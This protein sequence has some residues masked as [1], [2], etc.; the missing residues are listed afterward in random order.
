MKTN[1]RL[2]TIPDFMIALKAIN[3]NAELSVTD[4]HH[5]TRITYAHLHVLKQLFVQKGWVNIF[6]EGVKHLLTVTEK[7]KSIVE[8]IN[9]LL[10]RL[11]IDK[12]TLI[13]FRARTKHNWKE[14][15]EEETPVVKENVEEETPAVKEKVEEEKYIKT[16]PGVKLTEPVV[17]KPLTPLERIEA[18]QLI[19]EPVVEE[20]VV[21]EPVVEEPVAE[22]V[23]E[24]P[25]VEEPV[26]EEPVVEEP[27]VED[28]DEIVDDDYV[29]DDEDDVVDDEED[30]VVD[31][32][33]DVVDEVIEEDSDDDEENVFKTDEDITKNDE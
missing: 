20:P 16:Y 29:F 21:E 33:D 4:L 22:P 13:K 6:E 11:E 17:E 25:V 10:D 23:V 3:D 32:E 15:V 19:E 30:D 26:V 24:E 1:K 18:E 31:D 5:E 27:V 14:N 9:L 7:G 8:G 2:I 28:D 12:T